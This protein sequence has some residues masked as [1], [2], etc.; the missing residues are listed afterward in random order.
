MPC[1]LVRTFHFTVRH[2]P[3][4]KMASYNKTPIGKTMVLNI[5]ANGETHSYCAAIFGQLLPTT[6]I[7]VQRPSIHCSSMHRP[8][9]LSP[10]SI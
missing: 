6:Q 4:W 5:L 3:F 8:S 1:L 9:I 2:S 7:N 10:G